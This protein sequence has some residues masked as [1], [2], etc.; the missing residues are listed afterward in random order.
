MKVHDVI[1]RVISL[2]YTW[3]KFT[4]MSL[5]LR[6]IHVFVDTIRSQYQKRELLFNNPDIL[7]RFELKTLKKAVIGNLFSFIVQK[8][9][10][11]K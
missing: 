11:I 3:D 9:L 10:L 4:C 2:R 6:E 5:V 7:P 1:V 8:D